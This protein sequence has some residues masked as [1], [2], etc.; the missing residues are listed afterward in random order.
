MSVTAEKQWANIEFEMSPGKPWITFTCKDEADTNT[1]LSILYRLTNLNQLNLKRS[2]AL[3]RGESK[4]YPSLKPKLCRIATKM[5]LEEKLGYEFDSI[6]YFRQ[7][8]PHY[9]SKQLLPSNPWDIGEWIALMQHFGAATRLLDWTA[10]VNIAFYFAVHEKPDETGCV[11]LLWQADFNNS[12]PSFDYKLNEKEGRKVFTDRGA[13]IQFGK[14]TARPI[15]GILDSAVKTE[16]MVAQHS[17]STYCHQQGADH[18]DIIGN[19]LMSAYPVDGQPGNQ[20][21][22][23]CR[24]IIPPRTKKYLREQLSKL[25]VSA[26]TLFPGLDG[27]GRTITEMFETHSEVYGPGW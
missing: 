25:G 6:N 23:L 10:S 3:F 21:K 15:V 11:W 26:A 8:A 7:R 12:T 4:V 22:Q 19:Q 16:R 20:T 24:F 1:I 27:L 5:P 17:L 2:A 14:N 13:F 9:L 18:G